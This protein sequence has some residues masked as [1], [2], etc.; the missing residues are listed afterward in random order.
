MGLFIQSSKNNNT[1]SSNFLTD[2]IGYISS[3]LDYSLVIPQILSHI[4]VE[5]DLKALIVM[6]AGQDLQL[7]G[8]KSDIYN[9][10]EADIT[11]KICFELCQ[12]INGVIEPVIIPLSELQFDFLS[13][14]E[15]KSLI[16]MNVFIYPI[17]IEDSEF[18]SIWFVVDSK[19]SDFTISSFQTIVTLLYGYFRFITI[20]SL[21]RQS[22]K[23]LQLLE[24]F[25]SIASK[26]FNLREILTVFMN[27]LANVISAEVG[28]FILWNKDLSEREI[29]INWGISYDDLNN[30]TRKD[31]N[32]IN[33]VLQKDEIV[34][35]SNL[36]NDGFI[37]KPSKRKAIQNIIASPVSMKSDFEGILVFANKHAFDNN[38]SAPFFSVDD[39]EIFSTMLKLVEKAVDNYFIYNELVKLK[40]FNED[41]LNSI[42]SGIISVDINGCVTSSNIVAK[43]I[44]NYDT[45][46]EGVMIWK[47]FPLDIFKQKNIS[48]LIVS[49]DLVEKNGEFRYEINN[50]IRIFEFIFSILEDENKSRVGAVVSFRDLTEYNELQKQVQRHEQLAALGEL[51]AGIAH[52]IKNPLTSIQGFVQLLPQRLNDASFMD[53]FQRVLSEQVERMNDIT[54]RLLNF[55]SPDSEKIENIYVP[56]LVE[57]ALFLSKFQMKKKNIICTKDFNKNIRVVLGNSGE[58]IRVFLNLIINAINAMENNGSL[59]IKV[60]LKDGFVFINGKNRKVL[61]IEFSDNGHGIPEEDKKKI[62]NPF[63]T[64]SPSGTGLGLSISYRTVEQHG[65]LMQVNSVLG[66]GTTMRVLLPIMEVDNGKYSSN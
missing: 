30:I 43:D 48:E 28:T 36:K 25:S 13:A 60:Y 1:L 52:E 5:F 23:K 38:L 63:Y 21:Q 7:L 45:E 55:S 9:R 29:E 6:R 32:I 27:I 26:P 42:K 58:L 66:E 16:D 54:G 8:F 3:D 2:L 62:F 56:D 61:A 59:V 41:I 22:N 20:R 10:S 57:D 40:N 14:A 39:L 12:Q 50:K 11:P 19:D 35:I 47:I 17:N 51:A 15:I 18:S 46:M 34:N 37:Y 24:S 65:G 31:G 4:A 49:G 53:K 44:V 33:F 64:T